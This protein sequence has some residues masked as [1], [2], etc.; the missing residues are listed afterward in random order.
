MVQ[1][2]LV[3][4]SDRKDLEDQLRHQALHD[5]LTG[6][7]NRV[8]FIDR[9]SH[10]LVR[11]NRTPGVAALFM[12]LDDFKDIND[13]LGHAAGDELLRLVAQRL[14]GVVRPDDTACR[15]GGD[16]FAFLLE[17]ADLDRAETVARR[18]LAALAQPFQLGTGTATLTASVG[19]ATRGA[20]NDG[21][22]AA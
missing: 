4:I 7:P 21:D 20:V 2:I 22:G 11:R 14:A 5:P 13:S 9:L 19:V 18:I 8:L 1:G 3:D 12:D 16:E 17:D 10:A 6:L 15:L